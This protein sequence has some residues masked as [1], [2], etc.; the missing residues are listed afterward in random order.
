M[1]DT[2]SICVV[3]AQGSAL[4]AQATAAN[5]I[6]YVDTKSCTEAATDAADLASKTLSWYDGISGTIASASATDNISKIT[7][8]YG[9]AGAN[10][11]PV[12]SICLRA[13][14]ASQS[15]SQAVIVAAMSDPDSEVMLPSDQSPTQIVRFIFGLRVNDDGTVT[16]V[17]A[18]G[19]TIA[20]LER[21][22][23]LHKAGDPTVGEAQ[24]ILG[25]KSFNGKIIVKNG[26]YSSGP[27]DIGETNHRFANAWIDSLY[28]NNIGA[29]TLAG[30]ISI[31]PNTFIEIGSS[32]H[33]VDTIYA[34]TINAY[35]YIFTDY[36]ST[37]SGDITSLTST[38]ADLTYIKADRIGGSTNQGF[39]Y[40]TTSLKPNSNG[41]LSIGDGTHQLNELHARNIFASDVA[42][43]Y[44]TGIVQSLYY[45]SGE[46]ALA[47][48][49]LTGSS[50]QYSQFL[51][52]DTVYDGMTTPEGSLSVTLD[53]TTAPGKWAVLNL[54][55]VNSGGAKVM[56]V[57]TE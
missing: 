23:S 3:T 1:S 54:V 6:V 29:F 46:G 28:S 21:F 12:K 19:A 13:R 40:F 24:T 43:H 50:V 11:Q 55:N 20:D 57:R 53:G 2:F 45:G 39:L 42:F 9:N 10:P 37:N 47:E 14:L 4:I 38:N 17:Y 15:D 41:S 25:D 7:V 27:N 51:R 52:G 18:D 22:V 30:S 34:D 44:M 35:S 5:P 49:F 31:A 33:K 26:L 48:I 56:A 8:K 36:I 32:D 16:I